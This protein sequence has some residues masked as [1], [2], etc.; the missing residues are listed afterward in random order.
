MRKGNDRHEEVGN[1][2]HALAAHAAPDEE[3]RNREDQPAVEHQPA[4]PDL[5]HGQRVGGEFASPKLAHVLEPRTDDA[6]EHHQHQ[7]V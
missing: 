5:E 6:A 7:E 2:R 1:L 3:H 4:L